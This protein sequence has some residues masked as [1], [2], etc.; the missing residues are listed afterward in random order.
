MTE[1]EWLAC[2]DPGPMLEFL[3]GK[4]S[5]RKLRLFCVG[6]C[7][8][9]WHLL[10]D[11]QKR[12]LVEVAEKYADELVN[13]AELASSFYDAKELLVKNYRYDSSDLAVF[14]TLWPSIDKNEEAAG[15]YPPVGVADA[16]VTLAILEG[17]ETAAREKQ[18]E[19]VRCVFSN[20]FKPVAFNPTWRTSTVVEVAQGIYQ[21]RA[22]ERLPVL[23]DALEEAGCSSPE[24]LDHCRSEGVHVRGCFVVDGVLAR[25]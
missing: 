14:Y 9:I 3:R 23:G 17:V 10:G 22:F 21:E 18:S 8:Q 12:A 6:C 7:R 4:V 20:P 1:S 11:D 16:A 15:L 25:E 2:K 19:L 5:D 13:E 24:I